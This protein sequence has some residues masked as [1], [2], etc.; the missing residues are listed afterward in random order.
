MALL[1][2]DP[3]VRNKTGRND[4]C[5]CASGKKY[6][7]CCLNAQ[8]VPSAADRAWKQQLEASDELTDAM[9]RFAKREFPDDF[10]DAWDD[11]N[12][13][14]FSKPIGEDT[15]EVQ[16]FMPWFLFDWDPDRPSPMRRPRGGTARNAPPTEMGM[17][18]RAFLEKKAGGL[19]ELEQ[20]IFEQATSQPV[21]FYDVVLAEPGERLV[22]RDILIGGETE[23]IERKASQVLQ[24]GDVCYAQIWRLPEVNTLGRS[25]PIR[26]PPSRK[27]EIIGLRA[28]LRK[29]IARKNRELTA[30]DIVRHAE[31]VREVYLDIRDDLRTRPRLTNTDGDDLLYHTMTFEV[32]SAQ[33]AFDA[34]ASLAWGTSK[35]ELWETAE[36]DPDGTLRSIEIVWARGGNAKFETWDNTI[37][38][39]LEIT[40][41]TLVAEVNSRQRAE[42]LRREIE[43]RLGILVTHRRTV[44]KTPEEMVKS[45]KNRLDAAKDERSGAVSA[46]SS[47]ID[48]ELQREAEAQ[49]QRQVEAWVHQKVPALGNLTPLQAVKH[50]DGREMVEALLLEWERRLML[51]PKEFFR[52]DLGPLRESLN[53]AV[54]PS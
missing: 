1:V 34:L 27:V 45:G 8:V 14:P 24:A 30:E 4:P 29:K 20:E 38:G 35:E 17:V 9:L 40:G 13:T 21:S 48:P 7:H 37:L 12:Q 26:I 3:V 25:A 50:P 52:P 49:M 23:V 53:L 16:I 19:F 28:K 54:P 18:A 41:R 36:L 6:K 44:S 22:L 5:P 10:A 2:R 46:L 11:F 47:A 42:T 43:R 39:R 15:Q 51:Q 33:V 31:D 32:G